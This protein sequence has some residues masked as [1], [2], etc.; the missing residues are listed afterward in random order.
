M[1]H[2]TRASTTDDD[3]SGVACYVRTENDT[4]AFGFATE[5]SDLRLL[6]GHEALRVFRSD[7]DMP[8]LPMRA[9]HFDLTMALVRGPLARPTTA[10]C[11]RPATRPRP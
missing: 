9:D 4:D 3:I 2:S 7:V 10:D 1:V 8:A 11:H 5:K 6:T